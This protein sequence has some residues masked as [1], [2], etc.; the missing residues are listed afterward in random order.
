M[1]TDHPRTVGEIFTTLHRSSFVVDQIL[2][3]TA[4]DNAPRSATFTDAARVVPATL[5]V[6]ARKQGN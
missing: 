2:E 4:A 3:P 6:R 5:I 1:V